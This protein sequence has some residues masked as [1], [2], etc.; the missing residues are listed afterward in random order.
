MQV[1]P[2]IAAANPI[3]IPDVSNANDNIRAGAKILHAIATTFFNDHGL[4]L[5]NKT[6]F[7]FASYDA[8]PVRIAH[9][10]KKAQADGLDPDKWFD[11]VELAVAQYV[12]EETVIYVGNVYKYY[13]AYKLTA[14][15]RRR[16]GLAASLQDSI[17]AAESRLTDVLYPC[18]NFTIT[19][20]ETLASLR[21][22]SGKKILPSPPPQATSAA[23]SAVPEVALVR[24]VCRIEESRYFR[25]VE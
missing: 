13:V 4:D 20:T 19:P 2:R 1:I 23:R 15:E 10:R 21:R 16:R 18:W 6:F 17:L 22:R 8:G 14:D 9:L 24:H 5:L 7:S 11:N 12:G 3:N 25:Q